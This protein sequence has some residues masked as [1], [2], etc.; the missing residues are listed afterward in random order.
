MTRTA[1]FWRKVAYLCAIAVLFV[2][3]SYISAPA[4]D[5][6][7]GGGKLSELRRK[8]RLSQAQL[9]KI[10]P[11]SASM[12]LATLG[13][14]GIAANQLWGMAHHY[15]KTENWDAFKAT[16]NQISK[17][18]PNFVSVWQFQAW[19]I[20]Y[21]VSVEFDDFRH[22]YHWVKKGVDYLIEGNEYNRNEPLLLWDTGWFFGHKMGRADE[23]VQFR[24][25]FHDDDDFHATLP[26]DFDEPDNQ[27]PDGRP[28]NWKVAH[29]YFSQAENAV[30]RGARLRSLAM[31]YWAGQ[32]RVIGKKETPLKGKNPLVFHSDPP[33]ALIN[34]ADAIEE[35]GYLDEVG[36]LAWRDAGRA[37]N[38]YG[39]RPIVSSYGVRIRLNDRDR[40]Q[41]LAEEAGADLAKLTEGIEAKLVE[42]RR[43]QLSPEQVAAMQLSYGERTPEQ[44]QLVYQAEQSL[45]VRPIDIANAAPDNLR[46]EAKRLARIVMESLEQVRI[47]DRYRDIVNFVYWKKRCEAE[48]LDTTVA[49]R[50]YVLEADQAFADADLEGAREKYEAAWDLWADVFENYEELIDDV[51]GEITYES[52][53][54]YE[55][56]LGQLDERFPPPGFKLMRLV[57]EFAEITPAAVPASEPT[58]ADTADEDVSLSE[59]NEADTKGEDAP[60]SEPSDAGPKDEDAN[61]RQTKPKMKNRILKMETQTT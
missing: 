38:V 56:L 45:Q 40:N 12:T 37:W 26:V 54:R 47:I 33:K 35:D 23:Y 24:R 22:R 59:P 10:D 58:D 7:S 57:E 3:L 16:L 20:S 1:S 44:N 19:N 48:Q 8:E 36:Q 43:A 42:E 13:M 41:R 49:A 39:D 30:D 60:A 4:K 5:T 15:K 25:L 17:L 2:P 21:N 32:K 11:A 29:N 6:K 53:Q 46:Q 31:G 52:V 9:G 34:Y 55:R 28:D 51:E 27:G 14:R 61:D 18:Q 50:K